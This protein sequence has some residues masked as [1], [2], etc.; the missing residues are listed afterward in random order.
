MLTVTSG[1]ERAVD[2]G[3]ERP[4][5]HSFAGAVLAG[6]Q[7]VGVGRADARDQLQ[8]R[9]HGGAIRRS[10]SGA[11]SP[12]SSRFSASRRAPRAKRLAQLDLG[13]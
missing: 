1:C 8:H 9:L 11:P 6:D 10:A 13:A 3:V 2:D 5:D 7:H 12:R 4:G